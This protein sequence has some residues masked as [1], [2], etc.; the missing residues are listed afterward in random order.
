MRILHPS[1]RTITEI[2]TNFLLANVIPKTHV[3]DIN[4]DGAY[5]ILCI[6]Q[7][8][9]VDIVAIILDEMEKSITSTSSATGSASRP[10]GYLALTTRLCKFHGM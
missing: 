1:I 5:F 10:L 9:Q 4:M 3:L 2:Y 8:L 6:I 7:R